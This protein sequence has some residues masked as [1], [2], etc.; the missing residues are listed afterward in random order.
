MKVA[1]LNAYHRVLFLASLSC[2]GLLNRLLMVPLLSESG[3]ITRE[4]KAIAEQ[5]ERFIE[6]RVD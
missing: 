1:D 4:C 2:V 6:T 5:A 3:E